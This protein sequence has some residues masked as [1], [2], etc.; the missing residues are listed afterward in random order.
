MERGA[1]NT[2]GR[3]YLRKTTEGK[4][5]LTLEIGRQVILMSDRLATEALGLH[6]IREIRECLQS[7]AS[8]VEIRQTAGGLHYFVLRR[9]NREIIA[10]SST[11]ERLADCESAL[12][13]AA[14]H[15]PDAAVVCQPGPH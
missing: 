1:V 3:F 14:V 4:Y 5:L 10:L 11:W 13:L 9:K 7:A 15:A 2:Q 6:R 8:S 12:K